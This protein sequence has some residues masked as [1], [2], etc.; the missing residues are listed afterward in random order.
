M[1]TPGLGRV[2]AVQAAYDLSRPVGLGLLHYRPGSL[3]TEEAER[4]LSIG[5]PHQLPYGGLTPVIFLDY[6]LGRCVKFEIWKNEQG[7]YLIDDPWYDHTAE[8]LH[9]LICRSTKAKDT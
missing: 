4:L 8:H 5:S 3:A 6:V 7:E 1:V 9:E 2:K